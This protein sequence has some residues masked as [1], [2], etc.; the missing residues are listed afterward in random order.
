MQALNSLAVVRN[1]EEEWMN[2][3]CQKHETASPI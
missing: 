2:D 3:E 1:E